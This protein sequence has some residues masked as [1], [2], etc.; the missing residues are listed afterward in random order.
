MG[1]KGCVENDTK[2]EDARSSVR[3]AGPFSAGC[4]KS[5]QAYFQYV[6]EGTPVAM[7]F[8][9]LVTWAVCC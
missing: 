5:Q 7:G 4:S 2:V 6:C 8:L 9:G 1:C 3:L